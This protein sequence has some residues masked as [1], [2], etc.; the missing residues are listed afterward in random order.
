V[1]LTDNPALQDLLAGQYVLGTMRGGARR[2]FE[3]MCRNDASL[4]R[5]VDRWNA[6]L[7]PLSELVPDVQPAPRVW[8]GLVARVPE[9]SSSASAASNWWTSVLMWRGLAGAMTLVAVLSIGLVATRPQHDVVALKPQP[10][11]TGEQ[12]PG[13]LVA[14]FSAPETHAPIAVAVMGH[15]PGQVILKVV[16]PDLKIPKDKTLQLWLIKPGSDVMISAGV[17]PDGGLSSSEISVA[18]MDDLRTAKTLGLSLEPIGGSP[19]PTHALGF[20]QWSKVAA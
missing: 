14:T 10:N 9:L 19:Q 3:R 7:A 17:A 20:G 2:R 18:N 8:R 6:Q 13:M 12:A 4:Q 16:A 5:R 15:R 11:G 1:N